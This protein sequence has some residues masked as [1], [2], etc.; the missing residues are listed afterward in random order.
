MVATEIDIS[1]GTG[2]HVLDSIGS[3]YTGLQLLK[4]GQYLF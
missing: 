2:K 4:K 1:D 3:H